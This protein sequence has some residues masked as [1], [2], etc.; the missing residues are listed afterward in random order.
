MREQFRLPDYG[1]IRFVA[2]SDPDR[3]RKFYA[4]IPRLFARAYEVH[5]TLLRVIIV[6]NANPAG[7]TV[8]G[9]KVPNVVAESKTLSAAGVRCERYAGIGPDHLGALP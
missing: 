7:S 3:A 4:H 8:L 2:T 6:K 5:G 1:I 9:W